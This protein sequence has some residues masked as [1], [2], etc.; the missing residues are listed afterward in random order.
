MILHTKN[1]NY[2]IL[3][4]LCLSSHLQAQQKS[5]TI[6]AQF[7]SAKMD[8]P[9]FAI[10]KGLS[11]AT[12]QANAKDIM[13]ILSDSIC[14]M[15]YSIAAS[16]QK[17]NPLLQ[18]RAAN[19]FW[20]YSPS[21]VSTNSK[22]DK[23]QLFIVTSL[24][25]Q[26]MIQA[27]SHHASVCK[28]VKKQTEMQTC[29]VE[30][31]RLF[32]DTVIAKLAEV[33][34]ID[35]LEK[36]KM[37]QQISGYDRTISNG[38]ALDW[39]MP[40]ANGKNIVVSVKEKNMDRY[41]IDIQQRI[42]PSALAE[43]QT[44]L[45]ATS[46]ATLIGGAG[47]SFYSGRGI[48][49]QSQFLSTS[50]ANL[51]ADSSAYLRQQKITV[52]NHSYGTV[53]QPFYGAEALSYDLQT[54]QNRNI[55]HV[56]SFGN[57]G[58]D[59]ATIGSFANLKGFCNMTGNFKSAKNIITV[60][61]V[62]TGSRLASFSSAGPLYDGRLA[63][64]I[65]A[66]GP[67]G[68]SDAAAIVSGACAMLQQVYADQNGQAQPAASLI[69]A[70]LYNSADDVGLPGIDYKSGYGLLNALQAAQIIK[71]RN[72]DSGNVSASTAFV[73]QLNIPNQAANLKITLNWTDT[74]AT[75]NNAKAIRNDLDLELI[76]TATGF[77]YKPWC[78]ST[79][80]NKDSLAKRAIRKRD[81]L[82]TTE[83]I[84]IALPN[85]GTYTIRVQAN[86]MF[87]AIQ[88]FHIAYS[89]DTLQKFVFTSPLQ[90]ADIV[91]LEANTQKIR[92]R[93]FV[94]DTNALVNFYIRYNNTANWIL[95]GSNIKIGVGQAN[96]LL[97]DTNAIAQLKAETS[98]GNFLSP[99]LALAKRTV[100]NVDYACVDSFRLSWNKH[101]QANGYQV[102]VLSKDSAYLRPLGSAIRDTFI[103]VQRFGNSP[104]TY[105]VE[106]KLSNGLPAARSEAI[107]IENQGV[108]CFYTSFNGT[109]GANKVALFLELRFFD[110]IDSLVFEKVDAVGNRLR[111]LQKRQVQTGQYV[112]ECLDDELLRGN[113]FYRVVFYFNNGRKAF[114]EI[115]SLISSGE[116]YLFLYPN[117]IR[118]G[119]PLQYVLKNANAE[120]SFQVLNA[121]G[122]IVANYSINFSGQL[123]LRL[124]A[125]FYFYRLLNEK[126]DFIEA[127]RF[128]IVN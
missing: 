2:T 1:I 83:Q 66:L 77:V 25:L 110:N 89:W 64:Q 123:K 70:V 79:F 41:D 12:Q 26:K 63:P 80:P 97:A 108:K 104:L 62:D 46:M 81:S 73:K 7:G 10:V 43:T 82:N 54:S 71:Q 94:G 69:R 106:P 33:I 57:R 3:L 52:Q 5:N 116:R 19:D 36:P 119:Q 65:A 11:M 6:F 8:A 128:L 45:H 37:E 13:R 124:P 21:I 40:D 24:N 95:V 114:S 23:V 92:W 102:W 59:S 67:N 93:C 35:R 47:N 101:F 50:F 29:I 34:F 88:N 78:L 109:V 15:P 115:I 38:L 121:Q 105:A 56:F 126:N 103:V 118:Y 61:A 48:A 20:K 49:W 111:R 96:V 42:Q 86:Q 55:V 39:L 75:L 72:Y 74:T 98:F 4:L 17:E 9:A 112:Y 44:D 125:G 100:I 120:H 76:E 14:I 58:G 53:V 60:A 113:N 122:S 18:M 84:S 22:R 117:P 87:A 32:V 127:G 51:F 107:Q 28:I 91:S 16:L 31:S 99:F 90:A 27:L 68:T 30:A 85:A